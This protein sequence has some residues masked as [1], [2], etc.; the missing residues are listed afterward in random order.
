MIACRGCPYRPTFALRERLIERRWGPPA[1]GVR[2]RFCGAAPCLFGLYTVV[3][4]LFH[5]LPAAKRTGAVA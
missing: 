3:T 2:V 1:G 5:A 4:V